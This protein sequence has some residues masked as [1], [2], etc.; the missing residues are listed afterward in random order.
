MK[1]GM[2]TGIWHIA[3]GSRLLQS[4]SRVHALGFKYVDLHGTFHAGP[5][6]LDRQERMEIK[7]RMDELGLHPRSY[8]LHPPCNL[9]SATQTELESSYDYL[10]E[11]IDLAKAWGMNQLMLNAGLWDLGMS[12]EAAWSR[13]VTFIQRLCDAAATHNIFI[14]QEY[15]PFVWFLVNDTASSVRMLK[16]VD[17]P[18][19]TL[20]VDFGHMALTRENPDEL[21][22]LAAHIIHAHISDH[23][24]FNHTNQIVG[25]GFARIESYL[26]A[27]QALDIDSR[28]KR[29]GYDELVVSLELGFPGD[30]IEKPDEWVRKSV[31]KV[32]QVAP[33]LTL[34]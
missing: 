8:V 27:L 18:N 7:A 33:Y 23:E 21:S 30:Q 25:S 24:P 15:E 3:D 4:L 16:D 28:M 26:K 31:Q 32:Q 17:R 6:H 34:V 5:K 9:S 2:L 29:F 20:L 14:A 13:A 19:F 10:C 12:R 22:K 11:G 1:L